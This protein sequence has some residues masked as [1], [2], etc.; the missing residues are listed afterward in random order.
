MAGEPTLSQHRS[1]DPDWVAYLQQLLIDAGYDPGPVDGIFGPRTDAAVR[2]F[3]RDRGLEADGVV[4][5]LTW[6]ALTGAP[7]PDGDETDQSGGRGGGQGGDERLSLP[8]ARALIV[9]F[10][11][12]AVSFEVSN[13]G[14]LT[15]EPGDVAYR[16]T[17]LRDTTVVQ[18]ENDAIVGLAPFSS[19]FSRSTPFLGAHFPAVYNALIEVFDLRTMNLLDASTQELDTTVVP[20]TGGV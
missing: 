7:P 13:I 5:P 14:E 2:E 8:Q 17:V 20:E 4:G 18:E 19:P 9:D 10:N 16:L 1:N 12:E 3:Q 6:A 15:W 11:Q